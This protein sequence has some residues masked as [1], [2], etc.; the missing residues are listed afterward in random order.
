MHGVLEGVTKE[1][2]MG[3]HYSNHIQVVYADN[4]ERA[5]EALITKASMAMSLGIIVNI[6]GNVLSE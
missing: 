4:R 2:F 6:C 3:R 5:K 1:Q